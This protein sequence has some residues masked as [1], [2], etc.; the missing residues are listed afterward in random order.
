M[1]ERG[2]NRLEVADMRRDMKREGGICQWGLCG[3]PP[4]ETIDGHALCTDHAEKYRET[5]E[6]VSLKDVLDGV[7]IG[8]DDE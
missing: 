2:P 5:G 4:T 6:F 7:S 1:A 3:T 8:G